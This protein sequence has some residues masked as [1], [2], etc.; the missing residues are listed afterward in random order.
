MANDKEFIKRVLR[1]GFFDRVT[2]AP[3]GEAPKAEPEGE[4]KEQPKQ[5]PQ[6]KQGDSGE[7]GH[8][9]EEYASDG[10]YNK[11]TSVLKNDLINH[12]GVIYLL[13]G[14]KNATLRSKFRKEL[15]RVPK[16][17]GGEH[18]FY[19]KDIK[20]LMSILDNLQKEISTNVK[21]GDY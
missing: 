5:E 1:E 3:K 9:G 6:H 4:S 20:K 16:D 14:S 2:E 8:A 15:E 18:R 19:E 12:A 13:W 11:V 10:D 21:A 17:G 7:L